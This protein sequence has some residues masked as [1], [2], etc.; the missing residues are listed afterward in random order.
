MLVEFVELPL[1][2]GAVERGDTGAGEFRCAGWN[3]DLE[4]LKVAASI[5]M[6]AAVMEPED[7]EGE[8]TV[9]GGLRLAGVDSDDG[10]GVL[11]AQ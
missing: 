6:G 2:E 5:A 1:R 4:R 11:A 9:D 7:A 3:D 10:A 8:D